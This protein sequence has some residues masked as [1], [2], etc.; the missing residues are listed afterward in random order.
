MTSGYNFEGYDIVE[1]LVIYSGEC[2]L[3][4]GFLSTLGAG[5]SD[6]LG[7][8][9]GRYSGKLEQA[10]DY[11]LQ[12]L[13]SNVKNA[14]GN[15]II[16]LDIDYTTFSS[17]IMG[18][19]A[20]GTAV[21]IERVDTIGKHEGLGSSLP[22]TQTNIFLPFRP[23][24][25]QVNPHKKS[26]EFSLEIILRDSCQISGIKG[27]LI[28]TTVFDETLT[29][30]GLYF[31]DFYEDNLYK[32]KSEITECII[33]ISM[34]KQVTSAYF[35]VKK[36]IDN[37]AVI[38]VS[39]E[40]MELHENKMESDFSEVNITEFLQVAS[41]MSTA[42]EVLQYMQE[43]V[44]IL[45]PDDLEKL[46]EIVAKERLYGNMHSSIMKELENIFMPK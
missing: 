29:F 42:K 10:K 45:G 4:T 2:A 23:L 24:S 26:S 13:Y 7:T 34:L 38:C 46:N 25:F 5:F 28:L 27:D 15:A 43:K 33:P 31:L 16:G 41:S 35:V 40:N 14:G 39:D 21:K 8:N 19:I 3:G 30:K 17:D 9:S 1:Y 36:Y 32:Y 22:I 6:F 37:E 12:E 44:S 20:N 18:V 11:A